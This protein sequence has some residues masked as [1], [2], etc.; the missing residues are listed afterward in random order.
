MGRKHKGAAV[1]NPQPD[2]SHSPCRAMTSTSITA[3]PSCWNTW[4]TELLPEAMPPVRPTRNIFPGK[5]GPESQKLDSHWSRRRAS[6]ASQDEPPQECQKDLPVGQEQAPSVPGEEGKGRG[7]RHRLAGHL[8]PEFGEPWVHPEAEN[9]FR[10]G[11]QYCFKNTHKEGKLTQ[12]R[13]SK[14]LRRQNKVR[15]CEAKGAFWGGSN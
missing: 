4:S 10:K 8:G 7:G 13:F 15:C 3:Q 11:A 6:S 12:S 9:P 1:Q 5:G 14:V 2:P